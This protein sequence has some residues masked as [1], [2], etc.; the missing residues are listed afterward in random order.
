MKTVVSF[1]LR[2][3]EKVKQNAFS[4]FMLIRAKILSYT[5][6]VRAVVCV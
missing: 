4:T 2:M 6:R 3:C 5:E 1:C